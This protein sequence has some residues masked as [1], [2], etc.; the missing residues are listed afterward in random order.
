MKIGPVLIEKMI[1]F[2]SAMLPD[3]QTA[4]CIH[5][6]FSLVFSDVHLPPVNAAEDPDDL[7]YHV[8]DLDENFE[9]EP[10]INRPN[11]T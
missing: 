1:H 11:I 6:G 10:E 2:F 5:E 4:K 3:E 8:D 9:F 7:H